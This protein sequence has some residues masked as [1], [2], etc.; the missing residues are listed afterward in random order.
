LG[1]VAGIPFI[2]TVK[3]YALSANLVTELIQGFLLG[4]VALVLGLVFLPSTG[5]GIPLIETFLSKKTLK[6]PFRRVFYL[7]IIIVIVSS[8]ILIILRVIGSV[9]V[10][11]FGGDISV[12]ESAS[13]DFLGSYPDLWKW[14]LVSFHAGVTEEIIFRFG[15]MN[16]VV[17]IGNKVISKGGKE[18]QTAIIWGANLIAGLVFGMLHLVGMMSVPD[19]L[20]VQ[21]NVVIQNTLVGLVFGWFYWKYGLESAMLTHFLLDVFIYVLMNPILMTANFALILAW[22]A[23]T[24]I[25]FIISFNKY[26]KIKDKQAE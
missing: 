18:F 11:L 23:L 6:I 2:F 12:L 17:W 3:E 20:F 14:L 22:L 19:V 8:V 21:V 15:L 5:L 7:S 24:V 4:V 25:T 1:F 16:L 13:A 26:S 10:I 9:L